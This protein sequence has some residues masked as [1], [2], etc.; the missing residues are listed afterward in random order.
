[1]YEYKKDFKHIFDKE[2]EETYSL[3][4]VNNSNNMNQN[5]NKFDKE[6]ITNINLKENLQKEK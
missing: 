2:E 5:I 4:N 1:M 3:K 6:I